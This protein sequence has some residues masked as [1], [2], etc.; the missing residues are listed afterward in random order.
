MISEQLREAL[1]KP[2]GK[3]CST[4]EMLLEA[5]S[6]KGLLISVGDRCTYDL[7]QG[8]VHPHICIF[9]FRCMREPIGK[10]MQEFLEQARETMRAVKNP[11]G[12]ITEELKSAVQACI[13]REEGT[14]LVEGEDDLASLLVLAQAPSGS[15]LIYG[16]PNLGAVLVKIDEEKRKKA[17]AL[18]AQIK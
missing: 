16:Q 12:E 3:V 4:H 6:S 17:L 15:L 5:R 11:A 13:L 1:K 9:D 8:G 10:H 2:F 18:L 14:L 7:L